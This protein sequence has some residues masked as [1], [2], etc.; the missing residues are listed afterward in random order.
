MIDLSCFSLQSSFQLMKMRR[1]LFKIITTLSFDDILDT[2]R[3]N[4][5]NVIESIVNHFR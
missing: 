5:N 4:I 1:K 3:T 2:Y